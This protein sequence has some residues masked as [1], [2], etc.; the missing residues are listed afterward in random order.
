MTPDFR[1]LFE[2]APGLYLVLTRDLKIVAVSD[3]YLRATMTERANIV[4][5]GLFEVFP[6]NPDDSDATGV[7]NLRASLQRVLQNRVADEMAIQKYDIR[8]PEAGGGGFEERFWSP[9][10]SP[11]LDAHGTVQ[12]IIHQVEDVTEAVRLRN[13]RSEQSEAHE[14][15]RAHAEQVET[16]VFRRSSENQRL[17]RELDELNQRWQQAEN[18][19]KVSPFPKWLLAMSLVVL[20][21]MTLT[22]AW[23]AA[24]VYRDESRLQHDLLIKG[25]SDKINHY[26]EVL[27]NSVRLSVVTAQPAW[28]GRY[29]DYEPRLADAILQAIVNTAHSGDPDP[30]ARIA[31]AR[32]QLASMEHR[33]F[34]L[35]RA[36][37]LG[38]A[39]QILSGG[40]YGKQRQLFAQAA[41]DLIS[42]VDQ[43]LARSEARRNSATIAAIVVFG[44]AI[45]LL[46]AI[47]QTA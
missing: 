43:G 24:N 17:N 8:R 13:Q 35:M 34:D 26:D 2:S 38:G 40:A 36:D 9:K 44:A 16:E 28:E 47:W 10:N 41:T 7:N 14:Q 29:R 37:Q 15:L 18:N 19:A 27:T 11:V 45:A 32:Q 42:A 39:Q 46:S 6:D 30:G 12:Y 21:A 20:G 23:S 1:K 22:L 25:L 33:I 31:A 4:G 5:R 3:A